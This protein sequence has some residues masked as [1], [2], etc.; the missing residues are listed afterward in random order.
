[1]MFLA[2]MTGTTLKMSAYI[3]ESRGIAINVQCSYT[4][5][6]IIIL[7]KLFFEKPRKVRGCS[8]TLSLI[9]IPKVHR[10]Y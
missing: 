5:T 9:Y 3:L 7:S 8:R 10:L 6:T 2:N 1:M 4:S